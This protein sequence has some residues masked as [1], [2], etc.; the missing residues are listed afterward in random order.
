MNGAKVFCA[1]TEAFA[2][3]L[4]PVQVSQKLSGLYRISALVCEKELFSKS[5]LHFCAD[6]LIL[7]GQIN[8]LKVPG[9]LDF[10]NFFY[11]L[12]CRC[13]PGM[14]GQGIVD[15]IRTSY[16]HSESL[17]RAGKEALFAVVIIWR[18]MV[19]TFMLGERTT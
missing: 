15:V 12:F 1:Q 4:D 2:L 6:I 19:S 17:I 7:C 8:P 11:Y 3:L 16:Q 13:L 14:V 18:M 9:G 5:V 10:C